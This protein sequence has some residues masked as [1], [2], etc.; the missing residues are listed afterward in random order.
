MNCAFHVFSSRRAERV[1][2]VHGLK[3]V[4]EGLLQRLNTHARTC[5]LL[6]DALI[7]EDIEL[8]GI[9]KVLARCD[10]VNSRTQRGFALL[11]LRRPAAAGTGNDMVISVDPRAGITLEPLW[12]ALLE[13]DWQ[14]LFI[15]LRPLWQVSV[16]VC[17]LA[18]LAC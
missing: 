9:L 5:S 11:A 10:R 14:R 16:L 17:A 13:R 15:D 8:A 3:D 2:G 4:I 6:V 1:D 7:F 12:Q 18:I